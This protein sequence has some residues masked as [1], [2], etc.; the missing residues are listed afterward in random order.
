[1]FGLDARELDADARV[2]YDVGCALFF[3]EVSVLTAWTAVVSWLLR[4][5][6]VAD[7]A[8]LSL[9]SVYPIAV[10]PA[11]IVAVLQELYLVCSGPHCEV[12]SPKYAWFIVPLLSLP[13]QS[14]LFAYSIKFYPDRTLTNTV[15]AWNVAA[16]ALTTAWLLLV[17]IKMLRKMKS[18]ANLGS[19]RA[20]VPD[21]SG[22]RVGGGAT[23]LVSR[24]A[25]R[26]GGVIV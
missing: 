21:S 6:T 26:S 16:T 17:H 25:G 9:F 12:A 19:A 15:L 18:N 20:R 7:V 8:N 13:V 2:L 3:A 4:T 23:S 1:M 5:E 11:A 22:A 14:V 10:T 24:L